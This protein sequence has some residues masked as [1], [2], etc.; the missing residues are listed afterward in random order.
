MPGL[1]GL[2]RGVPAGCIPPLNGSS[3]VPWQAIESVYR[4]EMSGQAF[5]G[6]N[7]RDPSAADFGGGAD[8]LRH[9]EKPM[10][11]HERSYMV[12]GM[13]VSPDWLMSTIQR[14]VEDED[15]RAEIGRRPITD[16]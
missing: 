16:G 10:T 7:L 13:P 15:A 5:I 6:L 3:F 1:R 9:L 4:A 14:Y 8:V 11:G 12:V 2:P